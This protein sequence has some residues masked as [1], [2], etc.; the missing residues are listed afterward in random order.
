MLKT[1][2]FLVSF[3]MTVVGF[4]YIIVYL[5]LLSMGYEIGE[6]LEF[7][8]RRSECLIGLIGFII[9]SIIIFTKGDSYDLHL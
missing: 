5:N 3:G 6:Y 8:S 2:I 1:F 7:I 4:T 9:I